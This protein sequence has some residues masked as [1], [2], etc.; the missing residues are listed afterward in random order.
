MEQHITG[1]IRDPHDPRDWQWSEIA[2]S[3]PPHDWSVE[4]DIEAK[5]GFAIPP[6]DQNGSYSCG[7]QAER[8]YGEVLH[9][10]FKHS[11]ERKSAKFPYAQV[12]APG[13]GSAMRPLASIAINKGW[14][15]EDDCPSYENGVAPTEQFMEQ[16]NDITSTA[17]ANAKLDM[18]LNYASVPIDIDA[19][20]QAIDYNY[21][22]IIGVVG[23]NNGTWRSANPQPPKE[24]QGSFWSHWLYCGKA[25]I[26]NGVKQIGFLNSWGVN[27]GTNGWQWIDESYIN[28]ILEGH[29]VIFAAWTHLF[30][31]SP[32][33]IQPP[34]VFTKDLSLGMTDPDI[35]AL[36][37]FLQSKQYFPQT[38]KPTG[39]FGQIT[40]NA[41]QAYQSANNIPA[42]GYFGPLSRASINS[43]LNSA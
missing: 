15:R 39:Y 30:N 13:G 31:T 19:I 40:K 42:T 17:Y 3:L 38:I 18:A 2:K 43:A 5:I 7:G 6:E 26:L 22:V 28:T 21:G 36:Q 10:I 12:F 25:R 14:A 24:G 37:G 1:A 41:L 20:A 9:A 32:V 4:S 34:F 29:S 16:V 27:T 33:S 35:S 11:F 23:Q 8:Y